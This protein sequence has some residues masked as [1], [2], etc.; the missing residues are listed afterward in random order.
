MIDGLKLTLSGEE[1]R[2]LLE[3]RIADH[4]ESADHWRR[5]QSRTPEEQTEEEPLLPDHICEH[6]TERHV[7]RAAVLEFIRTHIEAQ[8]TYRLGPADLEF[9]E[10]LPSKPGSIEQSD[11]EERTAV[12]FQLERLTKSVRELAHS[13]A[14]GTAEFERYEP[15]PGYKIT[16]LDIEGGPEVVKFERTDESES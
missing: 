11:Y 2:K 3:E 5:E 4:N 12:G 13:G 1:I 7:W 14:L 9:G 15:P 10:L 16:R 8:A 6:E